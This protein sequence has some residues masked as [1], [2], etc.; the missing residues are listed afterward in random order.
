M[1]NYS[2]Y[3]DESLTHTN[4]NNQ[5]FCMA[6]VIINDDVYINKI[7]PMINRLKCSVWNHVSDPTKNVLHQ[8]E[9]TAVNLGKNVNNVNPINSIFKQNHK[10]KEVYD[11]L[12][13]ILNPKDIKVIGCCINI[14]EIDRYFHKNIVTDKYFMAIQIILEN[15]CHFLQSNNSLGRIFYES[16]GEQPDSELRFK[17]NQIRAIGSMFVKPHSMQQYIVSIN[18]PCKTENIIGL[19]IADFIPNT[20]ARYYAGKK[21]QKFNIYQPA[22]KC[23]YDG[24]LGNFN[25]FGIKYVP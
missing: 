11:G 3:L 8:K 10:V 24:N 15:Y 17:I 22:R 25:R 21:Q 20:F 4:F 7:S 9:I 23:K 1:T 12:K 19:Q 6:G 13:N 2:L 16:R 14:D 5:F 18:F